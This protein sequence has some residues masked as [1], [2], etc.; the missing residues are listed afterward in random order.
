MNQWPSCGLHVRKYRFFLLVLFKQLFFLLLTY[1]EMKAFNWLKAFFLLESAKKKKKRNRS[2]RTARKNLF[3]SG[4]VNRLI[5]AFDQC[6]LLDAKFANF[7]KFGWA[8]SALLF[9]DCEGQILVN[10]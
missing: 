2:K 10:F 1:A 3:F 7:A 9:S 8:N 5:V 6:F 4:H